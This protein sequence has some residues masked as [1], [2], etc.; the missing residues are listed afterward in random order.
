VKI[1]PDPMPEQ[2]AQFEQMKKSLM[3]KILDKAAAER[4]EEFAWRTQLWQC[5]WSFI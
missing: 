2:M 1:M 5:S 4:P 3:G